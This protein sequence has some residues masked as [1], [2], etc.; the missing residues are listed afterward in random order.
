MNDP[1]TTTNDDGTPDAGSETVPGLPP[2]TEQAERLIAMGVLDNDGVDLTVGEFRSAV[3]DLERRSTSGA[4]LVV[5]DQVLPV[6]TLVPRLKR[7]SGGHE[8]SGFIVVD[9][10]DV[11]EFVPTTQAPVPDASVYLIEDPYRGDDMRNWSPAEA[12]E[13]L[14][15]DGR[16]PFTISEG[17]HWALQLPEIIDRNA[18]YMMIGSRRRKTRGFDS[19]TPA[20]WI[21]N[22]TGRDGRDRKGAPKLGW[23]W[24]NNRHT[25]LGFASGSRRVS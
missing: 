8:R 9:M 15:R 11:E 16:T 18:C 14:S 3:A 6:R 25:W 2:L 22:G 13:A 20:L 7:T 19:R 4:L 10:D 1:M 12:Q 24:W 21:S 23:C 5:S 17:V